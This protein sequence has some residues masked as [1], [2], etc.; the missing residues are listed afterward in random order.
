MARI[1]KSDFL[2]E[3]PYLRSCKA[4][5]CISEDT[6]CRFEVLHIEGDE[7]RHENISLQCYQPILAS[8]R[9][10]GLPEDTLEDSS[11]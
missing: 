3:P 11:A 2:K 10:F 5:F 9:R 7:V 1:R 8:R 6:A 4:A